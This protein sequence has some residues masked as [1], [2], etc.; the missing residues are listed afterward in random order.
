MPAKLQLAVVLVLTLIPLWIAV[1]MADLTRK[2]AAICLAILLVAS[3]GYMLGGIGAAVITMTA[4][5]V[6]F[7]ASG[8][9]KATVTKFGR[10]RLAK[11]SSPD[12]ADLERW[13]R[14]A[15]RRQGWIVETKTAP[16]RLYVWK[17][18]LI[19]FQVVCVPDYELLLPIEV[20]N[21]ARLTATGGAPVVILLFGGAPA[22][23][24]DELRKYR[25]LPMSYGDL[26][27][28]TAMT[29][30]TGAFIRSCSSAVIE[31][32]PTAPVREPAVSLFPA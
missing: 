27:T 12:R 30:S 22:P 23:L 8:V 31:D 1:A 28:H 24:V 29:E 7:G 14:K 16:I 2:G 18:G 15:L 4:A 10:V 11:G 17:K 3:G 32:I 9:A 19:K 26:L 6:L 5:Y 20:R 13:A 21:L 25:L